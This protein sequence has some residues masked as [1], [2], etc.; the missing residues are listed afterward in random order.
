MRTGPFEQHLRE[1]IALNRAR[2]PLYAA[3]TE[4]TS[5][6]V[7]RK[8]LCAQHLSLPIARWLD[9]KAAPYHRAGIPLLEQVFVSMREA[10]SFAFP[11]PVAPLADYAPP[12]AGS[13]RHRVRDAYCRSSFAGAS[14]MLEL[15]IAALSRRPCFDCML[16]HLLESALRASNLAPLHAAQARRVDLPPTEWMSRLLLRLHWW[17]FSGAARLDTEARPLQARGVPILCRDVPPIASWPE[18]VTPC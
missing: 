18:G 3:L 15:E 4:G 2:A 14:R 6:G 13:I 8:L 11:A 12:M 17:G 10:P 9:H 7:S 1:A 16:R 5:L